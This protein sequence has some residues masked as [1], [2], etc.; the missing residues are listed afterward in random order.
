MSSKK[1][2]DS[3]EEIRSKKSGDSGEGVRYNAKDRGSTDTKKSERASTV[4]HESL[5]EAGH[6]KELEGE[7]E[8][9][10]PPIEEERHV[11]F[12]PEPV[13]YATRDSVRESFGEPLSP[14]D[15]IEFEGESEESHE[16]A[17]RLKGIID[18]LVRPLKKIILK[19]FPSDNLL[20]MITCVFFI[21]CQG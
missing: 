13:E 8:S 21:Q 6:Q 10:P 18:E 15:D 20:F 17:M 12:I 7:G 14:A 4:A 1:S 5:E 9:P 11:D 16:F 19:C 2:G 3:G